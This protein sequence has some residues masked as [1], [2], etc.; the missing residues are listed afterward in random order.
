MAFSYC[1]HKAPN[2]LRDF[3]LVEL[4]GGV[5]WTRLQLRYGEILV[6]ESDL[7]IDEIIDFGVTDDPSQVTLGAAWI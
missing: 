6:A 2:Y 4:Y 5:G 3:V 7:I 1:L